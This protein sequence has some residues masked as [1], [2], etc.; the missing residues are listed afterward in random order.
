MTVKWINWINYH[1]QSPS[2]TINH[3]QS[4]S[5]TINH[6]QS[7]SITINHYQSLSITINHYQ[8]LSITINHYQS[9]SITINHYQSLLS[10]FTNIKWINSH[11]RRWQ[12]AFCSLACGMGEA[13]ILAMTS[14]YD[15]QAPFRG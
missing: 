1:Y 7:L 12:V 9:L 14:F 11:H 13:S 2:I 8:S 5:I 3:H 10:L 15:A 6:Y 4:L